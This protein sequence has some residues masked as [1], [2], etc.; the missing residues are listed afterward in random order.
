MKI[1]SKCEKSNTLVT[2]SDVFVYTADSFIWAGKGS[3]LCFCEKTLP[4]TSSGGVSGWIWPLSLPALSKRWHG[5]CCGD[6]VSL[7]LQTGNLWC[8]VWA[9]S[10]HRGSGRWVSW[11]FCSWLLTLW[12]ELITLLCPLEWVCWRVQNLESPCFPHLFVRASI[13]KLL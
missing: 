4:E 11:F 5:H 1:V 2:N 6:S 7:P 10:P 8:G 9:W 13:V 3:A 12:R